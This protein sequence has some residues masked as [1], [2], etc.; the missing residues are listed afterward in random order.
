MD[1]KNSKELILYV[2]LKKDETMGNCRKPKYYQ[3]KIDKTTYELLSTIQN[4]VRSDE[5]H[6]YRRINIICKLNLMTDKS[7]VNVQVGT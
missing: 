2:N 1:I 3:H 6:N 4:I 7:G 5:L